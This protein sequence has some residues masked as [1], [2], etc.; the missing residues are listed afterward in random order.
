VIWNQVRSAPNER[1]T[2]T[3]SRLAG[4]L[5]SPPSPLFQA[6]KNYFPKDTIEDLALV[7]SVI[8]ASQRPALQPILRR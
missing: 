3:A 4:Y 1:Y 8:T 7:T 6:F 5:S 2:P